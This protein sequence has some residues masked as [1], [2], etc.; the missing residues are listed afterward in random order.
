MKH[1]LALAALIALSASFAGCAKKAEAP[2]GGASDTAATPSVVPSMVMPVGSKMGRGSGTVTAV[3]AGTG[4]I[5]LNHG[6]I[7]AL[8]GRR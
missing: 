2:S 1:K 4:K 8:G 3:D 5:T 6:A 7:P